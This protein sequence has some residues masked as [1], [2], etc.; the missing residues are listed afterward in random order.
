MV[1]V[2]PLFLLSTLLLC[3]CAPATPTASQLPIATVHAS[4]AAQPWLTELYL[5]ADGQSVVLNVTASDPSIELQI[6]EPRDLV[7]PSY[8]IDQEEILIVTNRESPIQNLSLD[9]AQALFAGHG[10]AS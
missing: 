4:S 6:G 9:Q 8:Q 1:R 5:C 7:S 10:E 2:I 3:S